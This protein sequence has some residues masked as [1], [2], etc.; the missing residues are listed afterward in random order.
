MYKLYVIP[1]S[2]ACR[3][4]MLM[5]EHKQ[6]PYRRVDIVTLMHPVVV[7]L[8]GFDAGGQ[9]RNAGGRRTLGMRVGDRLGTVPALA[10]DGHRI[11][12]NH[13]IARF[14]DEHHPEPPLFPSDP[15]RRAAV[16]EAERWANEALQ[17]TARRI[18]GAAAVREPAT[19]SRVAGD[20]R[21]GYL[22]YKHELARRLIVPRI[23][24]RVFVANPARDQEL[25][26]D[27]AAMLDRIDAWI[28]DGVLGGPQLN[29]ADFMVAP[30][31][32][33]V[34]YRPDVMGMFEGR[35]ALDLVDRLL[36]E[37]AD[38]PSGN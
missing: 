38:R 21:M 32:A 15:G 10:A 2:H 5:L 23:L 13:G 30:S 35:P 6:V 8:H 37:P 16:E 20:G 11:S 36:P 12:T 9:T 25:L 17:M 22:L 31:L 28:A 1:G 33:L 4:A 34:L 26:S 19:F 24:G 14:L 29:A 3:S 27:L 18:P 7:R